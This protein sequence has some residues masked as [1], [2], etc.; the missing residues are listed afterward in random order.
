MNAEHP[1]AQ[2]EMPIKNGSNRSHEKFWGLIGSVIGAVAGIGSALIAVFLDGADWTAKTTPYPEIFTK[3]EIL[4]YDIFLLALLVI[5]AFFSA[6]GLYF[7]R[8]SVFPRSNV[9]GANLIGLLLMLL[10]GIMLFLRVIALVR[11][12]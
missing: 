9:F 6:A 2:R 1:E 3:R 5:G 4:S 8:R 11:G 10:A 12:V 7:A